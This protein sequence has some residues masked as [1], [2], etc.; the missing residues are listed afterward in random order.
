VSV[1]QKQA[2]DMPLRT[3]VAGVPLVASALLSDHAASP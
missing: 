3:P 2:A 1:A